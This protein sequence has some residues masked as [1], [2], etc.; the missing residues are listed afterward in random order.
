M[1]LKDVR[2]VESVSLESGDAL[3][4]VD[5]QN[6]FLPG[7]ALAVDTGDEIIA[8][9]NDM[10]EKFHRVKLP[11]IQTQDWHTPDH[12]SF[13]SVHGGK[14]PFEEFEA[15]GVGPVLWP[16]HCVQGTEGA[17]FPPGL[18]NAYTEGIIRKGFRRDRD[19][20]SGFLENDHET[21]TGLDGYLRSRGVSRVFLC[22]LAMDYCV[23]FTAMDG[24]DKGYDVFY[25]TDLTKP[26]GSPENS[27]STALTTMTQ[28]GVRFLRFDAVK[29]NT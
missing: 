7:G 8:G 2:H 20:Y 3:I 22:G 15:P 23:Y 9:V 28:K 13:A 29:T 17:Q 18:L 26:V 5:V 11:I 16:D 21:E 25:F 19:S 12:K 14:K 1:E 4:V 6:D 24:K 10:I 27:V